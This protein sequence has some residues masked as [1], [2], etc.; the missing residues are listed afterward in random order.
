MRNFKNVAGVVALTLFIGFGSTIANAGILINDRGGSGL[1]TNCESTN[2]ETKFDWGILIND[3][4]GILINDRTGILINDF[5]KTG[6]TINCGI[7]IN[8]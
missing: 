2:K 8:D 5:G 1:T 4:I 3:I 7:L 6:G